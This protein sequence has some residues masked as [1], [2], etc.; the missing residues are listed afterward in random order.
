[1]LFHHSTTYGAK[2]LVRIQFCAEATDKTLGKDYCSLTV[3][4]LQN[5]HEDNTV[6]PYAVMSNW[7]LR[8]ACFMCDPRSAS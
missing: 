8:E 1:M 3:A 7:T 5:E 4:L 2:S 6:S